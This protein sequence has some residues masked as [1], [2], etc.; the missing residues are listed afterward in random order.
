VIAVAVR[1]YLCYGLYG[2]GQHHQA[3]PGRRDLPLVALNLLHRRRRICGRGP[4]LQR[5]DHRAGHDGLPRV[6]V[7]N[8]LRSPRVISANSTA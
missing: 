8:V 7:S 1:R 2:L 6:E 4:D 5:G 3:R